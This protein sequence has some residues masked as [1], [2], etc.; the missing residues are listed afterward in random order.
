MVG[1]VVLQQI[2]YQ[3]I[4]HTVFVE[5]GE[6]LD[7]LAGVLAHQLRAQCT[8]LVDNIQQRAAI[9]VLEAQVYVR[10]HEMMAQVPCNITKAIQQALWPKYPEQMRDSTPHNIGML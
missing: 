9:N 6:A 10:M 5:K 3:T 8:V 1:S 2:K 7:N 4:L